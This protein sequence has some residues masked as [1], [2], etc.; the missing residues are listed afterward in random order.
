MMLKIREMEID[1]IP[2]TFGVRL[3]TIENA[4]T[5]S[6]LERDYGVIP[7]SLSEAMKSHVKGWV[8]EDAANIVGFATL[9]IPHA[10]RGELPFSDKR[11]LDEEKKGFIGMKQA[12]GVPPRNTTS[13]SEQDQ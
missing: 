11:D 7:H 12:H 13:A 4:V 3:S 6:E 5:M 2:A 10:A 8:C 1:D 9:E